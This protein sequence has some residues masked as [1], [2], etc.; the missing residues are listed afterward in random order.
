MKDKAIA[1]ITALAI[2]VSFALLI[3]SCASVETTPPGYKID[4][5]PDD[6]G[7]GYIG[8]F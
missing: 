1:L 6:K 4:T 8:G 3:T 7:T 5:T 2:V